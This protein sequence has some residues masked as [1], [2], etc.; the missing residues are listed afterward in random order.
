MNVIQGDSVHYVDDVR[1]IFR[2]YADWLGFDLC[3]QD[4]DHELANLPG[5]YAPPLG[6][7]LLAVDGTQIEGCAALRQLEPGICEMKRM[8]VRPSHRGRGLGRLL[9]TRIIDE[10]RKIGYKRMRLDTLPSMVAAVALYE[11]FGFVETEPYRHNPIEGAR[12][13]ELVLTREKD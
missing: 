13:M 10:A 3:F 9:A 12:F 7:L 4:F 5:D 11:S 2:E 6:R 8:Y 1:A